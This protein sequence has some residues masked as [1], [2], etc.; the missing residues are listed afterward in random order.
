MQSQV[1]EL[2]QTMTLNE[3]I[4]TIAYSTLTKRLGNIKYPKS[5]PDQEIIVLVQNPDE[6]NYNTEKLQGKLVELKSRGV[7]KSRNAAIQYASGKYLIFGD[8]DIT[9][10]EEGLQ[11]CIAYFESHPDCSIIMAQTSDENGKLR[12]AYPR[13]S[14]RFNSYHKFISCRLGRIK[15]TQLMCF[16]WISFTKFAILIRCLSHNYGAIRVRLKVGNAFL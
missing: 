11:E 6:S 16:F 5:S 12:K 14:Y 3:V 8:D 7:A 2:I 1:R 4:L 9:F 15:S 13:I 10:V